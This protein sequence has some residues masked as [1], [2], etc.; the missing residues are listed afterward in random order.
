MIHLNQ[1]GTS[2]PKPATVL[3][4]ARGVLEEGPGSWPARF[5]AAHA[6]VARAFGLADPGRLLLTPGC[7]S[8]LSVAIADHPWAAGDRLLTSALEHHA[9]ARPAQLLEAR[10]VEVMHVP[11]AADGPLDLA[12]LETELAR[13][14]VRLVAMTAACNVTGEL[15]PVT[16]IV[17]LAH[18][19]GALCLLDGAQVC[20]W[21]DLDLP[22]LGVDLFAFAGHKGLH[23]PWGIGGLYVA[24]HVSMNTPAAVCAVGDAAANCTPMPGYC[25]VGSVDLAALAG[26]AAGLDWLAAPQQADRLERA[27][28]LIERIVDKLERRPEVCILGVRDPARRLPTVAFTVEG[29]SSG[30]LA[31]ALRA[32]SIV[33]GSGLHCAPQAHAALGSAPE[34]AVRLSAGPLLTARDARHAANVLGDV[35]AGPFGG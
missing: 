22:R 15:L 26:L 8:A 34:G 33:V 5:H 21:L 32:E 18:E 23:A 4:A 14:G 17:R 7:T 31:D 28:A 3:A 35:L 10:G 12:L 9:L 30:A 29:R 25:D 2:W 16:E 20:G 6:R 1:A 19:H 13:G 24:P 27:R 11:R